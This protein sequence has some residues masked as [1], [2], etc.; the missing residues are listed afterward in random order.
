MEFFRQEYWSELTI[1]TPGN[2]PDPEIKP[3]A[4]VSLALGGRLFTT[5]PPGNVCKYEYVCKY[6]IMKVITK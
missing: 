3:G 1:P 4:L 2:I 5:V 6:E